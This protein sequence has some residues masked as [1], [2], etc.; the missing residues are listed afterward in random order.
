MLVA[1][2]MKRSG[3]QWNIGGGLA[4]LTYRS[5]AQSARLDAARAH[6]M[7]YRKGRFAADSGPCEK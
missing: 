1:E 3:M 6:L 4:I 7:A 2:R 5:L